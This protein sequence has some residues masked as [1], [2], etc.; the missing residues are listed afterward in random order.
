MNLFNRIA[1]VLLILAAMVL[2]PLPLVFP[3]QTEY[4][5][6]YAADVIAANLAWLHT[7]PPTAYVGVRV[8]LAGVGMMAFPIGLLFLALE[9]VRLPRK[10]VRLKDGGGE[11]VVDGISEHLIYYVDRLADVLRVQPKVNSKGKSVQVE[12]YVETAPGVNVPAKTAEIKEAARQVIEEQLGL[13]VRGE[14]K[15]VIKPVP[16]PKRKGIRPA[17]L[18]EPVPAPMP[19]AALETTPSPAEMPET[20]QSQVIEVKSQ[21]S[22]EPG[23]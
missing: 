10:T 1:I 6:R 9:V 21:P 14:T 11:L 5:L 23:L 3:E 22:Q 20:E 13:Q 2:I 4:A 7:L 8:I 16:Y 17:P 15:V 18:P 12:L 19:E